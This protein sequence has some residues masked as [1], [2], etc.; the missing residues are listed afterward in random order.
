MTVQFGDVGIPRELI[1]AHEA[2]QLVIF[3]GAGASV[4][5][6]SRLPSFFGLTKTIRDESQLT[7]A[8]GDL[9]NQPLDEVMDEIENMHDVDVHL[10]AAHHTGK[11]SSRPNDL[12]QGIA[13]LAQS[14][15]VRVVSTNYDIHL[16]T[17]L[18]ADVPTYL[19]PALPMGSDFTGLVYLHGCVTQDPK[20]LVIT[21]GDFGKAYL[22]EAWAT[23]FLERMFASYTTLFIGYS[24]NDVIM[25]YLARGLG[26]HAKPRYV[27]THQPNSPMWRQLRIIPVGYSPADD[28]RALTVAIQGWANLASSG[29]LDHQQQVE[30]VMADSRQ[31]SDLTSDESSY[32][33]TVI[34]DTNAVQFFCEHAKGLEWLAWI[35]DQPEFQALFDTADTGSANTW[36]LASWFAKT[37]ITNEFSTHALAVFRTLGRRFSPQ[38]WD[39][40]ARQ[41][42]SLHDTE[43]HAVTTRPW[44]LLLTRDATH[45]STIFLEMLLSNC[46]LPADAEPATLLFSYLTEPQVVERSSALGA[47]RSEIRL[48]GNVP[49]LHNTWNDVFKAALD[50][51]AVDLLPVIDQH[52]RTAQRDLN[53]SDESGSSQTLGSPIH[54]IETAS[55]SSYLVPLGLL[56]EAARDCIET[57]LDHGAS[58]AK[59][60]LAV[61][62]S[63][64]VVLLRRLAIHGWSVR[65][66][67]DASTKARWLADQGVVLDYDH[68]SEIAPLIAHP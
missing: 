22:T 16:S 39:A 59:S 8:I 56:V 21:A 24:H 46:S 41:L 64:D 4:A 28:H 60:Q 33:Q 38:L 30:F 47:L 68:Q 26:P 27:C 36:R 35:S 15:V 2:D 5:P 55:G 62:A 58:R 12:H 10:R 54:P 43:A 49:H 42:L 65:T 9:D 67:T 44:L 51:A 18:G 37:Y 31:P 25:K 66:D 14:R 29:L 19:S 40:T 1:N 13:D 23:R 7:D 61:W 57:L 34:A 50:S 45:Q 48:R 63:S 11:E 3:V 53:L 6:P 52:L 20:Q 32:L 17:M